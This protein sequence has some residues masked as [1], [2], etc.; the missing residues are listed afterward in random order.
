MDLVSDG[1]LS[2]VSCLGACTWTFGDVLLMNDNCVMVEKRV[3]S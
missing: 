2:F 3:I 1:A